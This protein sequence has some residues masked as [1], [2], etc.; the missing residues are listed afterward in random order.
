MMKVVW[1]IVGFFGNSSVIFISHTMNPLQHLKLFRNICSTSPIGVTMKPSGFQS[2][3]SNETSV[4]IYTQCL[5][6]EEEIWESPNLISIMGEVERRI[7]HYSSNQKILLA[8]EG[9]FSFSACLATA[10]GSATKIF[11]TSLDSKGIKNDHI[12]V[13]NSCSHSL[14]L[15]HNCWSMFLNV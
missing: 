4:N 6:S 14:F 11:A 2:V 15:G 3:Y 9:D 10:F 5:W 13:A 1:K 7:M 8:G 12:M